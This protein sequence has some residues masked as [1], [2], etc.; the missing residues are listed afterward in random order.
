MFA[1]ER[2]CWSSLA[3]G[4]PA[5]AFYAAGRDRRRRLAVETTVSRGGQAR[6]LDWHGTQEDYHSG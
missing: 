4:R 1:L 2:D 3:Q 6:Q 5:L